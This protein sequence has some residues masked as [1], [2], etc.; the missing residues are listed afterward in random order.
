MTRV[1]FEQSVQTIQISENPQF[2]DARF[3][4]PKQRRAEPMDGLS[5]GWKTAE[6]A[7]VNSGKTH[8]GKRAIRF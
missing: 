7:R 6:F 4:K 5:C 3:V 8:F 1:A 2:G